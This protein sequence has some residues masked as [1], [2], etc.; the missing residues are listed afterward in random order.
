MSSAVL[1]LL[2]LRIFLQTL[3]GP[4]PIDWAHHTFAV[5]VRGLLKQLF[6]PLCSEHRLA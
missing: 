5:A 2:L 6:L 4:A 3:N 1:P